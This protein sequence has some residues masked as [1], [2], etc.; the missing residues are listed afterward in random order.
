LFVVADGTTTS[1]MKDTWLGDTP[2]S[3]ISNTLKQR[4]TK[5]TVADVLNRT[6]LNVSL[7]IRNFKWGPSY[8]QPFISKYPKIII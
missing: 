1:F 4:E 6:L 3:E 2:L 5:T 7:D 8:M